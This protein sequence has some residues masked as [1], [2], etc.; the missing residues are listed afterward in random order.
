MHDFDHDMVGWQQALRRKLIK[1]HTARPGLSEHKLEQV[2]N[3]CAKPLTEQGLEFCLLSIRDSLNTTNRWNRKSL[4]KAK[5][6]QDILWPDDTMPKIEM[7]MQ[8]GNEYRIQLTH[9]FSLKDMYA[10]SDSGSY[11]ERFS[12]SLITATSK[13]FNKLISMVAEHFGLNVVYQHDLNLNSIR[14]GRLAEADI[15]LLL[16]PRTAES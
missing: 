1:K 7:N 15:S 14:K 5:P 9:P 4:L 16:L 3:F 10:N 6:Y 12:A 11:V 8:Y 13:Q 2:F